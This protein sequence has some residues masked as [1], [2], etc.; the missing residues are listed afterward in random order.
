MKRFGERVWLIALLFACTTATSAVMQGEAEPD[1]VSNVPAEMTAPVVPYALPSYWRRFGDEYAVGVVSN[2]EWYRVA[3]DD[4]VDRFQQ[5]ASMVGGILLYRPSGVILDEHP[6]VFWVVHGTWSRGHGDFCDPN[7]PIF[8]S[9]AEFAIELARRRQRPIEI[10]SYNW[11]SN[12]SHEARREAGSGLRGLAET[13]YSPE[14][15][16]GAHWG[17]GH[18]HG[19]NVLFVASQETSFDS[20]ISLGAPVMDSVYAPIHVERIY[21]FYSLNDLVQK[22]G[23]FDRRS[24]RRIWLSSSNGRIYTGSR[25][26]RVAN[27]FRVMLDGIDPGH[28]SL[29]LLVPYLWQI[30]DT[31]Q[32]HYEFHTHFNV[33]VPKAYSGSDNLPCVSI[34]DKVELLDML[35][36]MGESA[37]TAELVEKFKSELLFSKQQEDSFASRYHGRRISSGSRWWQWIFANWIELGFI[38]NEVAPALRPGVYLNY[39]L[40]R[41]TSDT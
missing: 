28:L 37:V 34:R 41:E 15:G 8:A 31:V 9:I 30:L 35:E 6:L 12:D 7:N 5:A 13:F 26:L 29:K 2:D 22:A 11:H 18:S 40:V 23:S 10:I 17:I 21:H 14:C 4:I 32:G 39:S 33:N 36:W 19:V 38:I 24:I 25:Y 3:Q 27:N 16:Y 1:L 20:I